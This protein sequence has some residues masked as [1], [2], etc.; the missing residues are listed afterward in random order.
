MASGVIMS[1]YVRPF[2]T[3]LSFAALS[4]VLAA[5]F[6]AM[7][8]DAPATAA[9]T[10]ALQTT[11]GKFIQDLGDRAIAIIANKSLP[12]AQRDQQFSQILN[13]SFDLKTIGRY[14]IG[15]SW[16]AATPAQ[17]VEYMDLFKKLV[18]KNYGDRM[19]LYTGEG[20]TVTGTR[21]ESEMD[22]TVTSDITHPDGSQPTT[23]NWRVRTKDGKMGVIDVEVE[24]VSLSVTQRQEYSAVI[25]QN[26]GQFEGLLQQMRSE[27]ATPA[28]AGK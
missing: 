1:R 27:L 9:H 23:I 3:A 11:Q 25:Q 12:K 13:D 8:N 19:T 16:N 18:I 28:P 10:Q 22:T 7:A 5:P 24:G 26:G 15:P 2:F 6:P 21:P 4:A 17:Q 14:V 20:F